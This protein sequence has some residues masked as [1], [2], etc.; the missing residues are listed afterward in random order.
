[1]LNLVPMA[2]AFAPPTIRAPA[3]PPDPRVYEEAVR[4]RE[5]AQTAA[6]ADSK[7]RGRGSTVFAGAQI[8]ADE[9]AGRGLLRSKRRAAATMGL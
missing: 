9:Q 3:P 4:K 7:S 8:A 5:E 2:L 6:I 1:L